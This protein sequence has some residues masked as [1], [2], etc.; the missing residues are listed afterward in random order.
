MKYFLIFQK[1]QNQCRAN[2][3]HD[4]QQTNNKPR[5]SYRHQQHK[6]LFAAIK[7]FDRRSPSI[8]SGH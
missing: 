2:K 5:K 8:P 3:K 6:D 4:K 1:K 7:K